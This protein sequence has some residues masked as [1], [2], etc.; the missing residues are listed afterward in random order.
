MPSSRVTFWG[1]FAA[2]I[3]AGVCGGLVGIGGGTVLVPLL[4]LLFGFD[5]QVAQ[6]TSLVALVPPTGLLAFLT[7]YHVHQ[8]NIPVGLMIIPGVFLGGIL[9][10][11]LANALSPHRMRAVFAVFLFLL[12]A[13]QVVAAWTR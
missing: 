4:V 7:Y 13:W 11:K 9:G 3:I 8:V 1:V 10:G 12:G 2:A 6:G 5:Q